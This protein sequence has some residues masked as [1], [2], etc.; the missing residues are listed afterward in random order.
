MPVGD[1][2]YATRRHLPHLEKAGRTYFITFSTRG[3]VILP[4]AARD[5]ALQCCVHDHELTNWLHCAVIM[6]DHVH[7]IFT[8]FDEWPLRKIMKRV[9]G[10]SSYNINTRLG[11]RGTVWEEESFDRILRSDEDIRK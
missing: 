2:T 11:R 4:P 3:R 10:V 6:P 1:D 8:P 7:M 9:K 5:I